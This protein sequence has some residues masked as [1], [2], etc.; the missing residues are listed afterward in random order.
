MS[1]SLP[2]VPA[3]GDRLLIPAEKV[4]GLLRG[5]AAGWLG[6]SATGEADLDLRTARTLARSLSD[7]ADQIDVECI[8]IMPVRDE[9]DAAGPG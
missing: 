8:A 3:S 2:L 5:V 6:A 1:T 4:T 7:L 9:G